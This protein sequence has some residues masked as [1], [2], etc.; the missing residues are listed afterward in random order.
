MKRKTILIIVFLV[1]SLIVSGVLAQDEYTGYTG[2]KWTYLT[3]V[4]DIESYQGAVLGSNPAGLIDLNIDMMGSV[5]PEMEGGAS[6][7]HYLDYVG[8]LGYEL[9][10][11]QPSIAEETKLWYI[12]KR[13][14][15]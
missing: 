3:L 15:Q 4:Y 5:P 12:F 8:E 11:L 10:S 9:V 1:V 14:V 7:A 2:T 6:I 13:P